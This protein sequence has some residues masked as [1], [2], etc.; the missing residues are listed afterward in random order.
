MRSF[1]RT[2]SNDIV[3]VEYEATGHAREKPHLPI[4]TCEIIGDL[5]L[6]F[7][8]LKIEVSATS[9]AAGPEKQ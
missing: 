5:G 7:F 4:C 8:F 3:A 2:A 9:D 6:I 1:I